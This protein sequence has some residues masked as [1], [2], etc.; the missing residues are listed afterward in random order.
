MNFYLGVWNS[1]TAI[2]D[3][4]AATRY[5]VL[6]SEKSAEPDF[7]GQVYSFYC[8]LT[9]LYPEI[10]MVPEYELGSCPWACG[11]DITGDHVIMAIQAE[12]SE[13]IMRQILV[14]AAQHELVCFDPQASKVH[15]PPQL[16]PT[17]AAA[18][19]VACAAALES[20]ALSDAPIA[21]ILEFPNAPREPEKP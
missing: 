21:G 20:G 14:L 16:R 18:A 5:L 4:E 10:E 15:L 19:G 3:D 8:H 1:P 17:N 6:N 2:S 9:S 11:L 7:D 13:K 12:Q